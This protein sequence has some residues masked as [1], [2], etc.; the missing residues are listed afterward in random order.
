MGALQHRG[1]SRRGTSPPTRTQDAGDVSGRAA[2]RKGTRLY[3]ACDQATEGLLYFMIVFSPWAFGTTEPWSKAVMD[4]AGYLLGGLLAIK[5]LLRGSGGWLAASWRR[6]KSAEPAAEL[7]GMPPW[8]TRLLAGLT[9]L[10]LAYCL[11]SALNARGTFLRSALSIA[12]HD[13]LLWLPHSYDSVSTWRAFWNY[14]AFALAFWAVVDWLQGGPNPDH[15]EAGNKPSRRGN[16]TGLILP[17]RLR[18]LLWVLCLNGALLALEGILQRASGSGKLLWLIEPTIN[19]ATE[20]QFGPYAYRSNAA[21]YFTLIWPV[22]LGFWW[23]QHRAAKFQSRPRST[24]HLLLPCAMLMAAC[25]LISLSRA[26]AIIGLGG[27][28]VACAIL[29]LAPGTHWKEKLGLPLFLVTILLLAWY[30]G[31]LNLARRFSEMNGE[32]DPARQQMWRLATQ[33]ARD[34]PL[35]GT[36]PGTFEPVSML[37]LDAQDPQWMAQLHND[38]LETLV[39]FG[40]L[41]FALILLALLTVLSRWFRGGGIPAHRVLVSFLWLALAGCLSYAAVDFPFQIYSILFL[42]VLLCAILFCLSRKA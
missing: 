38:W 34:F 41:G 14:L 26:G 27:I 16:G 19:K 4:A 36:G 15:G 20:A 21:Q 40:G 28:L 25:P 32:W 2:T 8:S 10:I 22:A 42:F 18:R 9:V 11:T 17:S 35:F 23:L 3:L 1:S 24:H 39:T 6:R 33:M 13:C 7:V 5:W 31:W 37:Y 29:A 30:A 12:Y